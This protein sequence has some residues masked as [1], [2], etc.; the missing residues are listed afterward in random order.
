MAAML[1]TP[2]ANEFRTELNVDAW[3]PYVLLQGSE[4]WSGK[5]GCLAAR[6]DARAFQLPPD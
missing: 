4:G 1:L 5:M 6:S 3:T 2:P